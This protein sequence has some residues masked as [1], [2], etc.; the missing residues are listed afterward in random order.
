MFGIGTTELLVILV[1]GVLV[2]G[3]ENLPKIVRTVTKVMSNVR[4]ISTDFQRTINLEAN[5]QEWEEHHA[6]VETKK[7]KKKKAPPPEPETDKPGAPQ[8]ETAVEADIAP[9]GKAEAPETAIAD[10]TAGEPAASAASGTQK[11]GDSTPS[12]VSDKGG[13]A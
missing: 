7:K 11:T 6:A 3:P 10:E 5:K 13:R 12:D 8:T 2:L 4:K 1:V 9:G